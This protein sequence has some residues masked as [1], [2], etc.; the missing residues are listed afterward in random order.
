MQLTAPLFLFLFLPLALA[1]FYITPQ[2][3]RTATLTLTSGAWLS[4]AN[5]GNLWGFLHIVLTVLVAAVLSRRARRSLVPIGV[6]FFAL[7]LIASRV[8]VALCPSYSYPTGLFFITLSAISLLVDKVRGDIRQRDTLLEVLCYLLFFPTATLGPAVRYKHFLVLLRRGAP[9]TAR[10]CEGIRLFMLGF[11]KRIAVA[12]VFYRALNTILERAEE[13][14]FIALPAALLLAI[15]LFYFFVSGCADMARGLSAMYGLHLPRD[16]ANL[17]RATAPHAMLYSLFFSV[18]CYLED[19][20]LQPLARRVG[21]KRGRVISAIVCLLLFLFFFAPVPMA[22]ITALPLL[23]TALFAALWGGAPR[24]RKPASRTLFFLLS[25]L[26]ASP[27]ALSVA[28]GRPQRVL[29]L[30]RAVFDGEAAHFYSFYFVVPDLQYILIAIAVFAVLALLAQL[31]R[32]YSDRF[33]ERTRF[34]L[35]VLTTA[36]LF[37]GFLLTLLYMMPQFPQYAH[38]SFGL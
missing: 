6:A 3:W 33:S 11:I 4:L 5:Y 13:M 35:S 32:R 23:G 20:L 24:A 25:V 7:S 34:S 2:R 10:F 38:S 29:T 26:F 36:L 9:S 8:L 1:L 31:Y 14:P 15:L 21:G 37:I 12:A 18:H 16:R 22:W 27:L 30:V 28:A 17:L 19:Y